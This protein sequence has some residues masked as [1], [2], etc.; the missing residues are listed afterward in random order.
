MIFLDFAKTHFL[1]LSVFASSLH[2]ALFLQA[3]V[4]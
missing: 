3:G 2:F 1:V 4:W